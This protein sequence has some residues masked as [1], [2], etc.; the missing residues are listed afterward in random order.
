VSAHILTNPILPG[1]H[2]DPSICRVGDDFY[3][4]TST[5]E[6]APGLPVHHSR[7]LRSWRLVGH[8]A[9]QVPLTGTGSSRGLFA[10]TIRFHDGTFYVVCTLV[11]PGEG[12]PGG[13]FLV[14]ATDPAGPWSEPV[15][16]EDAEGIDPSLFFDDDGSVWYVGTHPA[17][18]PQWPGQTTVWLR[19]LDLAQRRLVGPVHELWTG[20]LIGAVWAEGPH[21]YK[22]GGRY[23]LLAAEGGTAEHHAISVA[24]ADAVTG[25]YVGDRAN[26]VLTHR[27]LGRAFPISAVGHADLVE[28]A[29]GTW[30]AA[31]LAVRRGQ[32]FGRETFVVPVTWEDGWPRFAP[33]VGQVLTEVPAPDLPAHPWPDER[34]LADDF[35]APDLD[36]RWDALRALPATVARLAP[37]GGLV[38]P[39]RP[40]ELHEIGTPAFV[41]RRVEHVD[42]DV[43]LEATF[44]AAGPDERAGLALR[45]SDD[46]HLAV[47]VTVSPAGERGALAVR[48]RRGERS[49][50]GWVALPDGP[51]LLRA[52]IRG[53]AVTLAAGAPGASGDALAEVA[54]FDDDTLDPAP[55]RHFTGLWAGPYA[56][57]R[58]RESAGALHVARFAFRPAGRG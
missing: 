8:A 46:D 4:V 47:L 53:Q 40:G 3:L 37:A 27:H 20:A 29:D 32:V 48:S 23:Y 21:L 50:H 22:V 25:P 7:D 52:S 31:L 44:D 2:P 33:G 57:S 6:Y 49:E 39:L 28:L 15:W 26:P 18:D 10:P 55:E 19:E 56:T 38:L 35:T 11:S 14:T 58:G 42:V 13:N 30:W 51:V 16:L 34:A 5:F 43:E 54:A 9:S 17:H 36:P 45:L 12:Q 1:C 24:R 41:G